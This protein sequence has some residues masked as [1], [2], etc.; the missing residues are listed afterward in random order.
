MCL[1][2]APLV[3]LVLLDGYRPASLWQVE[4]NIVLVR[5]V[6]DNNIVPLITVGV[7]SYNKGQ[8]IIRAIQESKMLIDSAGGCHAECWMVCTQANQP[9]IVI[10]DIA[11]LSFAGPIKLIDG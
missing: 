8:R 2:Q 7:T 4:N 6:Y 1:S 11:I 5:V 3:N 9:G 10:E